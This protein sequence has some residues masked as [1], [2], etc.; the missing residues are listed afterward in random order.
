ML[1]DDMKYL[2]DDYGAYVADLSSPFIKSIDD[3]I[4][5]WVY[6]QN[7]I[8]E[9]FDCGPDYFCDEAQTFMI[10]DNE[11]YNVVVKCDIDST[12]NVS[13]CSRLYWYDGVSSKTYE[14]IPRESYPKP[15][16]YKPLMIMCE[17]N[18]DGMHETMERI[19][20]H[21]QNMPDVK[22]AVEVK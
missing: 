5:D 4:D 20:S 14:K 6:N 10:Y 12:K 15:K 18:V 11:L 9:L 16:T 17:I 22:S 7:D 3:A 2:V 19:L 8:D 1:S 21:V 13:G